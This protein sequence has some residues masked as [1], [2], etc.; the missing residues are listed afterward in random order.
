MTELGWFIIL[1]FICVFSDGLCLVCKDM[2]SLWFYKSPSV[3]SVFLLL[4][5]FSLLLF[6]DIL[7][8]C[9]C[10]ISTIR[11]AIT[12]QLRFWLAHHR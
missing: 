9:Y 10:L 2:V 8:I 1:A 7:L 12:E 11:R 5:L 6:I 3:I 4:L